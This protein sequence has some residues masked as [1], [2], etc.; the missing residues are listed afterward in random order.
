[1]AKTEVSSY[2]QTGWEEVSTG[3]THVYYNDDQP[4]QDGTFTK[5]WDNDVV[6]TKS[7]SP[8]V[9]VAPTPAPADVPSEDPAV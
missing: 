6:E 7:T 8:H 1:M 9:G 5:I 3:V 4:V 2:R